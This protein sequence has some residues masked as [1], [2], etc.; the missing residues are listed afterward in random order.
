MLLA[1]QINVNM[2]KNLALLANFTSYDYG[3]KPLGRLIFWTTNINLTFI[4]K[5]KSAQLRSK[6]H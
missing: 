6:N 1:T 5:Y 4:K 2:T 3:L